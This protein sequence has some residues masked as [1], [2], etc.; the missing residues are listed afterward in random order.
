MN[1]TFSV[2]QTGTITSKKWCSEEGQ[3]IETI[4]GNVDNFNQDQ[5]EYMN[6]SLI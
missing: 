6:I 4:I 5:L 2:D 1:T 3:Y